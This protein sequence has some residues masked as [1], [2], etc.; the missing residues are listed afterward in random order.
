MNTIFGLDMVAVWYPFGNCCSFHRLILSISSS[1]CSYFPLEV[2]FII[3]FFCCSSFYSFIY[4]R[5]SG[6]RCL[7]AFKYILCY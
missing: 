1:T 4:E 5:G 2:E 3:A 6:K 7:R